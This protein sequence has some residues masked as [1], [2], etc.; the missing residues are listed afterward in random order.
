MNA[1]M[2]PKNKFK[3]VCI[4]GHLLLMMQIA[5]MASS[6]ATIEMININLFIILN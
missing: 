3:G 1:K 5:A 2:T 6:H 4:G